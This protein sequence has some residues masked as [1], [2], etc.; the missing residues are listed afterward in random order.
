MTGDILRRLREAYGF[1]QRAVAGVMQRDSR[2]VSRL[3]SGG[4]SWGS[5]REGPAERCRRHN[6]FLVCLDALRI[7]RKKPPKRAPAATKK[8]E[9]GSAPVAEAPYKPAGATHRIERRGIKEWARIVPM[10]GTL[11]GFEWRG[12][13]WVR[14]AWVEGSNE[15]QAE[16]LAA[17]LPLQRRKTAPVQDAT[18]TYHDT[19]RE[20]E[21]R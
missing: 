21:W 4:R 13:E 10:H 5:G 17:K 6:R 8:T 7:L 18:N 12:G 15:F 2:A 9:K 3:E 16:V 11:R 14:A 20:R 19:L 1:S